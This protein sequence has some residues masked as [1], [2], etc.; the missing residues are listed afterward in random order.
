M[1]YKGVSIFIVILI[2]LGCKTSKEVELVH[3][4]SNIAFRNASFTNDWYKKDIQQDGVAGISLERAKKNILSK[5]GK[6][7]LV[8]VIDDRIDV[9]HKNV[10]PFIW[11]NINEKQNNGI[12]DDNN[13]YVDD[14]HGWNFLGN[15]KQQQVL[16]NLS[17]ETRI[18]QFYSARFN[19]ADSTKISP[20]DLQ[21]YN[22]YKEAKTIVNEKVRESKEDYISVSPKYIKKY[23]DALKQVELYLKEE[24]FTLK[25]LD[26]IKQIEEALIPHVEFITQ[27]ITYEVTLEDLEEELQHHVDRVEKYYNID[28]ND[29]EL[30]NDNVHDI[31]DTNYGNNDIVF[32]EEEGFSHATQVASAITNVISK[33]VEIMPLAI[34]TY[35]DEHDKDIALAIR[36]AVDNG[37]SIINMSS[38]KYF[39]LHEDWVKDAL[40]YAE[41]KDVLFITSAGNNA[42]NLD[43]NKNYPNDTDSKGNEV[44]SN[45]MVVGASTRIPN[46]KIINASSNY[47]K[48][49]V[50]IFAP[51]DSL[52]LAS[53]SKNKILKYEY[54]SGTS[55]AAPVV[56]GVA[57]LIRSYY[58]KLSA[59][60]VKHI[61]M[62]HGVEY[63]FPVEIPTEE[64]EVRTIPFN[65]LS[66][67]GKIVNVYNALLMA[68]AM[69]KRQ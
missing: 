24:N 38:S 30:L 69:S 5:R 37:A 57:A 63:T 65:Q 9:N 2:L 19:K 58:P 8:A 26:S 56:S 33:N 53:S 43:I 27:M 7:V 62:E 1:S 17:E 25:K 46:E 32:D 3:F 60:Q 15:D 22:L 47:G 51:G 21:L 14:A 4:N 10:M 16:H 44:L 11:T 40:K 49:E 42:M 34:S 48:N 35:G 55:F 29:R 64:D 59:K 68:E 66:K 12:D 13:G 28:Y 41:S 61:I 52:Y 39:S 67:S 18:V 23:K 6:S 50:D 54:V 20:T 31:N 36:Y 45:F